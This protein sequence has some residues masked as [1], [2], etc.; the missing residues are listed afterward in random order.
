MLISESRLHFE[1]V[2]MRGKSTREI[3]Y[4]VGRF[5]PPVALITR[6]ELFRSV[7]IFFLPVNPSKEHE[8]LKHM[9]LFFFRKSSRGDYNSLHS[10]DSAT[11]TRP[12]ARQASSIDP[13]S[14]SLLPMG[15]PSASSSG[16]V[17]SGAGR[18]PS[19]FS[20]Q[21]ERL[22]LELLPFKDSV[23]FH[24]WLRG[25][26]VRGSWGEFHR[27][28]LTKVP[29]DHSEPDKNKTAQTVK[30]AVLGR[31]PKFLAY[32]PD[33]TGWTRDDHH[34]RFIVTVIQDNML[35]GLWTESDWKKRTIEISKAV[36]EVLFFLKA[37]YYAADQNPPGYTQ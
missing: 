11:W 20:S 21:H 34:V 33:K 6:A 3:L 7:V 2:T 27:D 4:K 18:M 8:I 22:I 17:A 19:P 13:N 1:R 32:H 35:T 28:F 24:E 37:S 5:R 29:A 31:S 30:D 10:S 23:K 26:M 14:V 12:I 15:V 16:T 25:G 36:Y 9:C